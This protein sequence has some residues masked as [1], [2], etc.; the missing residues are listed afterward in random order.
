MRKQE[1]QEALSKGIVASISRMLWN[2]NK[3]VS[4]YTV[5][6]KDGAKDSKHIF[7][8]EFSLPAPFSSKSS[9]FIT[10]E[11]DARIK[12]WIQIYDDNKL[13]TSEEFHFSDEDVLAMSTDDTKHIVR[14]LLKEIDG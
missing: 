7:K 2:K 5:E 14:Q 1:L 8:I 6:I 11:K 12:R 13:R 10:I 9:I 4:S 3:T